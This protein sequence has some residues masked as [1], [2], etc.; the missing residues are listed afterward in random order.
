MLKVVAMQRGRHF[1]LKLLL[2]CVVWYVMYLANYVQ[3]RLELSVE[4]FTSR[5]VST[6]LIQALKDS[7]DKYK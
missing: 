3:M 7:E 1:C 2:R 6:L 4:I 5:R